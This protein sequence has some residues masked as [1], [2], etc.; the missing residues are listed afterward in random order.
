MKRRYRY[1][2]SATL[3]SLLTLVGCSGHSIDLGSSASGSGGGGALPTAGGFDPGSG[4]GSEQLA[5]GGPGAGGCDGVSCVTPCGYTSDYSGGGATGVLFCD[6]DHNCTSTSPQCHGNAAGGPAGGA[7]DFGGAPGGGTPGYGGAPVSGGAPGYGGAPVSGGAP[8]GGAPSAGGPA[9]GA[10]GGCG[11][12]SCGALCGY[13]SQYPG[14]PT[15]PML[16]DA[17]QHCAPV[18][19]DCS[20]SIAGTGGI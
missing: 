18:V 3:A 19:P 7:F 9:G 20:A 4:A 13:Y 15:Q 6:A 10:P 14:G 2:A 8:A 17:T 5:A 11:V 1:L 12:S 16:C